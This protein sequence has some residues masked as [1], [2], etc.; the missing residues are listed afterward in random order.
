MIIG[1]H[2]EKESQQQKRKLAD[3]SEIFFENKKPHNKVEEEVTFSEGN[4]DST[5]I[6]DGDDSLL[7]KT[8][9]D[10]LG[11]R[12]REE[13]EDRNE[14]SLANTIVSVVTT[15]AENTTTNNELII[16][17]QNLI[18]SKDADIAVLRNTNQELMMKV[19]DL[20]RDSDNLRRKTLTIEY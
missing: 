10:N 5:H 17:L 7:V 1:N 9:M 14:E 19:V 8:L 13:E 11:E 2:A 15:K 16:S 3:N 20:E 12:G 18:R 4:G 6:E